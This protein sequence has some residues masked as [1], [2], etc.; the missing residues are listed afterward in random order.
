[1]I[2]GWVVLLAGCTDYAGPDQNQEPYTPIASRTDPPT[3][4]SSATCTGTAC[5]TTTSSS[6]AASIA[7]ANVP[8]LS[9]GDFWTYNSTSAGGT[10]QTT[11]RVLS[12]GPVP[13]HGK[14][15]QAYGIHEIQANINST[16]YYRVSDLAMLY[17]NMTFL[18]STAQVVYDEP[19]VRYRFPLR[20]NATWSF[21]CASTTTIEALNLSVESQENGT[22]R[23]TKTGL[24]ETR[25]GTFS[26]FHIEHNVTTVTDGRTSPA[27]ITEHLYAPA[28]CNDVQ[29]RQDGHVSEELVLYRCD[30][31]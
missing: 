4:T 26:V 12:I 23:V 21:Q 15:Y 11:H 22:V 2:V 9:V 14:S 1:M 13:L 3:T 31:Q 30:G 29:R 25:A 19:C 7:Q 20:V 6:N 24:V 18:G 27:V 10:T 17:A 28:A 8:V 16:V 5:S